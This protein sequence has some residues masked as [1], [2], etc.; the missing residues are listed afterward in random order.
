M[1]GAIPQAGETLDVVVTR[2]LPF[3]VLVET[4]AGVAGLVRGAR[5]SAG[6]TLRVRVVE[7]DA[8]LGRFSAEP[9]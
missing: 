1:S 9:G 5:G 8:A 6:A 3:G 7:S 4:G 2:E